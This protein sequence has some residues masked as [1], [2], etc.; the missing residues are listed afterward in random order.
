MFHPDLFFYV[1]YLVVLRI[2]K[3]LNLKHMKLKILTLLTSLCLASLNGITQNLLTNLSACYPLNCD[4]AMDSSPNG[5]NGTING[6]V[7]CTTGHLGANSSAYQFGGTVADY[8]ALPNNPLLKPASVLTISGW[9]FVNTSSSNQVLVYSN[10]G[11]S[12]NFD[13]YSLVWDGSATAFQGYK[14]PG[15]GSCGS[16]NTVTSPTTTSGWHHVVWYI[17]SLVSNMI[18]DNGTI[19]NVNNPVAF[20]YNPNTGVILGGTNESVNAPFD[21]KIDNLRFW[22]RQLSA[23]EVAELYLNDPNCEG[24]TTTKIEKNGNILDHW[25]VEVFPN[26]SNAHIS[27]SA[28]ENEI[29]NIKILDLTGKELY[30]GNITNAG[31]NTIDV[32]TFKASLYFIE[33]Q[34]EKNQVVRK[35][36][37]VE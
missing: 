37:V 22:T 20:N 26:P 15:P 33:I 11:C 28:S 35:K 7:T 36:L 12:S 23:L 8:I 24:M 1:I 3:K 17:D 13:A 27:I 9:F 31:K 18:I 4:N 10:N 30:S 5:L 25:N 19:N 14:R 34:N 2:L 32:S 29:L 6:N 16:G 21:G